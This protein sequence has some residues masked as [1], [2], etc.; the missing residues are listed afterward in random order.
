VGPRLGDF[1]RLPEGVEEVRV[2]DLFAKRTIEPLDEGVLIRLPGL[3]VAN[4]D[5]LR[6]APLDEGLGGELGPL[7]TRTPGWPADSVS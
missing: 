3:D 2:E 6:R 1:A 7:S 4:A 5:P